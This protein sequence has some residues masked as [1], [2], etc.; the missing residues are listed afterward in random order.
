MSDTQNNQPSV[1]SVQDLFQNAQAAAGK[2]GIGPQTKEILVN[3]LTPVTAAGAQGVSSDALSSDR[4]QLIV[5]LLDMTSSMR[6]FRQDVIDAYNTMIDTLKSSRQADQ[7]L[8][9]AWTFNTAPYLLHGYTPMEFVPSL[10]KTSYKPD[11]ATALYDAI[12]HGLIGAVAY[13]QDLRNQGVRTKITYIVFTDGEDNVS[14]STARQVHLV[15]TDLLAQEIYTFVLVGFGE[16]GLAQDIAR[17][18]GFTNTLQANADAASIKQALNI[19]SR[20]L[21][22]NSQTMHTSGASNAFFS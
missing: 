6:P 3:N 14:R 7:M 9:S 11:D 19:V 5:T 18:I 15:V 2:S 21:I 1:N 8:L 20:S 13:G 10:N 17:Q 22:R 4:A 12:L 16:E